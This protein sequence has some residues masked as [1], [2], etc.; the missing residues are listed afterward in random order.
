MRRSGRDNIQ[1]KKIVLKLH[2]YVKDFGAI[3]FVILFFPY[4]IHICA[5]GIEKN[6]PKKEIENDTY[7]II[8]SSIGMQKIPKEEYLIG[9]LAASID[10][11]YEDEVL[12]AQAVLLRT[13]I[14]NNKTIQAHAEEAHAEEASQ[15]ELVYLTD[16]QQA[17]I[18]ISDMQKIYGSEF[19]NM[20]TRLKRIVEET[21]NIILVYEGIPIEAPFCAVSAGST[22]CADEIFETKKYPYLQ[23]VICESDVLADD[24]CKNY[25]FTWKELER[26]LGLGDTYEHKAAITKKD[27]AGYALQIEIGNKVISGEECRE[28]LHLNSAHMDIDDLEKGIRIQT[29]GL[30]HG[31][32]M[33]Q[34][35][36]QY[37]AGK[38]YDFIE[39]LSF[40][41]TDTE[42]EKE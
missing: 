28:K 7:V 42:I 29:K 8:E 15:A 16:M 3:F 10:T 34:K 41:Y 38:G 21:Q 25:Y 30:G 40:F 4:I 24:Y 18:S 39:I 23:S 36:A 13:E 11:S 32:G 12:K 33:S 31:L 26:V 17:Y 2:T 20:Y 5:Y 1:N 37:L 35:M 27:S 19:E 9:A 6:E 22:R 14:M